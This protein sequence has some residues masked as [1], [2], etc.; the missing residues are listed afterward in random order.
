MNEETRK[1]EFV[2]VQI[3]NVLFERFIAA[4]SSLQR[5]PKLT[6]PIKV[7]RNKLIHHV[8]QRGVFDLEYAIAH[9]VLNPRLRKTLS[10]K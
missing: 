8:F 5:H 10:G 3:S 1:N 2:S 7:D 4:E 6:E 9:Q